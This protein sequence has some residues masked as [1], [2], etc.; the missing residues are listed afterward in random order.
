MHIRYLDIL[1]SNELANNYHCL[2]FLQ[3]CMYEGYKR[4]FD[5]SNEDTTNEHVINT[6]D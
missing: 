5:V 4:R 2:P 6:T 3:Y 1:P